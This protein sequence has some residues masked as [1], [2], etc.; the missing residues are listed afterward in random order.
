[1][2]MVE[3]LLGKKIQYVMLIVTG[4]IG[5]I[6]MNAFYLTKL[7]IIQMMFLI[8][9]GLVLS[10]SIKTDMDII[11]DA[12]IPLWYELG[13]ILTG[14]SLLYLVVFSILG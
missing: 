14:V 11:L 12:S 9:L 1:M 7:S 10:S 8:G 13:M 6:M 2:N 4:I 5:T 3:F